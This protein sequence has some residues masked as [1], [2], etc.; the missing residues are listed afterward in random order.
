MQSAVAT[1]GIV[2][3]VDRVLYNVPRVTADTYVHEQRQLTT[4]DL[5][6]SIGSLQDTLMGKVPAEPTSA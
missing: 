4:L 1:N 2:H 3:V 5:L 6:V